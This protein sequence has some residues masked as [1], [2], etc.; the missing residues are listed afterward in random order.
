MSEPKK[1]DS[2]KSSINSLRHSIRDIDDSYNNFW[3]IFAELAQNSVDAINETGKSGNIDIKIDCQKRN[4]TI[5]DTGCGISAD[6]LP[7]LLNLFSTGKSD[8]PL[9]IGEKGVG[10]KYVLFQSSKFIIETSD[11]KTAARATVVDASTWKKQT[12]ETPLLLEQE[13]LEANGNSYTK[14]QVLG[15]EERADEEDVFALSYPQMVFVLRTKTA[16]GNTKALWDDVLDIK[17]HLEMT[18]INGVCNS[19]TIPYKYLTPI[20]KLTTK[21]FITTQDFD[22][23]NTSDRDDTQKRNKL[24]DKLIV[25]SNSHLM[26]NNRELKYWACFVPS[27]KTWDQIDIINKLA[28]EENLDDRNWMQTW[29]YLL[30]NGN[31][32]AATKGMPTAITVTPPSVGNAGYL[33]NFFIIFEDDSLK[34]DIGRKSFRGKTSNIYREEAKQVFNKFAKLAKYSAGALPAHATTFNREEVFDKIK[35]KQDLHSSK[36]KFQKNPYDQEASVVAIFFELIGSGDITGIDPMYMG[37]QNKYDLY[38]RVNDRTTI[39]EFKSHLRNIISD[40]SDYTKIFDEM[41]YI[42][43]WDVNDQDTAKLKDEGIE[44]EKYEPS[45]FSENNL[46]SCV[47]HTMSI[48]N[49]TPIYIIDLKQLV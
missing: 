43:C 1:V 35:N 40:F 21:D 15:I 4:V 38:A 19:E 10:L 48:T 22:E 32:T 27:R 34:F 41:D 46:P 16:I 12:N 9:S 25:S 23:W 3:D 42:V 7:Q 45:G 29:N 47:T 36:V 44:V 6:R 5:R 33:P 30:F 18:D 28:T 37:Y 20:E 24:R 13:S 17:V 49:V 11:G 39:I 2:L 8:D 31:I 14:I 26:H